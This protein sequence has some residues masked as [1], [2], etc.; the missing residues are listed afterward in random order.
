MAT[1]VQRR[2]RRFT[3]SHRAGFWTVAA[4]F[5]VVMAISALPTP[6]YVLYERRDHFSSLV[7]TVI[8]AVYALGV[9]TSLFLA[10]HVSDWFGRRRV[11]IPAILLNAA[12]AALFIV[13]PSLPGLLTARVISGFAVGAVTATATA[14]LADLHRAR[15][16]AAG[17]RAELVATAANLGGIGIGPLSAG[18]L[19][20]FLPDPLILP[21]AVFGALAVGLALAVRL[22]PETGGVAERPRYRTQ[23]ISVPPA[24]R[25]RFFAAAAGGLIA[26]S[27]FGLFSSLA[28]SFL[29][30]TLG[31]RSHALAGATAFAV[32]AAGA[33]AQSL[34]G[35]VGTRRMTATGLVLLTAGLA[36]VTV[37]VWLPD[38]AAFLAGGVLC[39]S[40]AGLLTKGGIDTVLELAPA[41]VR[42]EG[43]ATFFLAAYLGLSVPI[44]GLGVATQYVSGRVSLL[45][46]AGVLV[47]A[48]AVVGP[49]LLGKAPRR[50]RGPRSGNVRAATLE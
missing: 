16:T 29:A 18:L 44:V 2:A 41:E 31:Y 39:G 46:F 38:L 11:L 7:V 35:G 47:L 30:V 26:F 36:L 25:S 40:G 1:S 42:A 24:G 23:R 33:V 6:L 21:F 28:P 49:A 8:F 13:W 22:V 10:G 12:S 45:G 5:V 43:L 19:A 3:L 50:R 34:L 20:Q 14:Y 37:A 27:V 9:M 17:R 48:L 15:E 4:A 32:F